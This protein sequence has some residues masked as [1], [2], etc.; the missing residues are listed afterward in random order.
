MV[1][2]QSHG[3]IFERW[4][5]DTLF[6]SYAGDYGQEW[7]IPAAAN[8][9]TLLPADL[10]GLPVSVKTAQFGSPI[11][12]GDILRQRSIDR[13]FLMIVGFWH[14]HSAT[15]KWFDDIG[16]VRFSAATWQLLWNDLSMQL[17]GELDAKVKSFGFGRHNEARQYAKHW[18]ELYQ[19]LSHIIVN[20]KIDSKNQRRI[21]CSLPFSVF[22]EH[23]GRTAQHHDT[24]ELF[25]CAFDNPISSTPRRFR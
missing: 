19:A 9:S 1:E 17:I 8:R 23:A 14:K 25:G 24:P 4:V 3:F 16:W 5:R 11:G 15:E 22:W 2:V 18:K 10:R 12:L 6:E 13:P 21:Q 7:D 20:P